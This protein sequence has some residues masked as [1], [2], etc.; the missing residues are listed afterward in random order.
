[1]IM[2][3][4]TL[5]ITLATLAAGAGFALGQ[6]E[7]AARAAAVHEAAHSEHMKELERAVA[8]AQ[9]GVRMAQAYSSA[10]AS[11]PRAV[12]IGGVRQGSTGRA[13]IIPKDPADLK[14]LSEAE[15]D[16]NVMAHILD[17]AASEERRS[18]RAM[19]IPVF[20]RPGW[21]G[22]PQQNLLVEGS[23]AVFFLNVNFPLKPAPDKAA[24][25]DAGEKPVSEWDEAKREMA[26]PGGGGGVDNA[27]VFA[28]S[29]EHVFAWDGGAPAP[30][31]A[32]KVEELK[33]GLIVALKNAANI[34]KLKSDETVTI[35]VTGTGAMSGSKAI[36]I[37]RAGGNP[38]AEAE[39]MDAVVRE[40]KSDERRPAP[41]PV[42]M[43]LRV[44][45]S[46]AEA[47]QNGKQDLDDFKKKVTVMIY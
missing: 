42:R 22:G 13:L 5:V 16:M 43:V 17:K 10:A 11:A 31:D 24:N 12:S 20:S 32:S 45:K 6:D 39:E 21:G 14:G 26:R 25:E 30:Y 38:S 2:K 47:F 46:D 3:N 29:F 35:V 27:F 44:R 18:N 36:K 28:E 1:M 9:Q 19:G 4:T 37:R 34:R 40:M 15:E 41:S 23:G 8:A 33:A 7:E